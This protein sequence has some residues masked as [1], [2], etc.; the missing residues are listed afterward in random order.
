MYSI[1][2][3]ANHSC[4][5]NTAV[6]APE[7]S[8]GELICL[9]PIKAGE[10]IHVSYITEGE[11]AKPAAQRQIHFSE[12]WEFACSCRR[13]SAVTDDA[14]RFC[15]PQVGCSGQCA[16]LRE[17][18]ELDTF[19]RVASCDRCGCLPSGD[20]VEQWARQECEVD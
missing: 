1:I 13:C 4:Y 3:K 10:E 7:A 15:C 9:R 5:P 20:V 8:P 12:N 6:I 16:A 17:E 14:R 19:L 18:E 2:A 11:L